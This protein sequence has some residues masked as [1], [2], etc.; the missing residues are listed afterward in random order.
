[1]DAVVEYA[2]SKGIKI[3]NPYAYDGDIELLKEQVDVISNIKDEFNI[4][5]K[6]T[7]TFAAMADDD[8]AKTNNNTITFNKKALRSREISN[9]NLQSD[10]SL[11]A[12]DINGISAHEMGHII[13]QKYGEKG[14][15][16][17]KEIYYNIYNKTPTRDDILEYLVTNVSTYTD[18]YKGLQM[19]LDIPPHKRVYNEITPEVLS[20]NMYG[21]KTDFSTEFVK[22]LKGRCSV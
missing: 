3:F 21:E 14:L 18:S 1:M 7:V 5:G 20:K 12:N 16:I 10:N 9:K 17:A 8:F 2:R 4:K 15:D 11:A 13:S 22:L 19:G 6:I